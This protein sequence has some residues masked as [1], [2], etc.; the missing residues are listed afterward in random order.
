MPDGWRMVQLGEVAQVRKGQSFT[1]RDLIVGEIPVIAGGMAPAYY[2]AYSNREANTIT[3]SASGAHAGFVAFHSSPILATDCSTIGEADTHEWIAFIYQV[4]KH[5]QLSLYYR[6]RG[7]AQP[8]VYPEDIGSLRIALPPLPEQHAIADVLD[9]ID[10]AIERTE[11]VIAATENLHDS[12]LHEL[13]TRGVP[14]WHTEWKDVPG[15]GTIPADWEVVRLGEVAR[16]RN[17][18]TPSRKVGAYWVDGT[19]PF[20]KTGRV[21]DV[22]I[23]EPDEFIT[24]DAVA[25]SGAVV[26]PEGSVLIAMI[27]QGK[28]RGMAARLGFDAAI[29]QN[30]AAV[31][32][33]D[34]KL[35]LDFFFAYA[36][37]NY[38]RIRGLGQGSNQDAL[39]C[40]L[41]QRMQFALP[42]LNE[43]RV[44]YGLIANVGETLSS[45][46]E[47][48]DS[49]CS[50]KDATADHLLAGRARISR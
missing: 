38:L 44:L 46:K 32:D 9:S 27:G 33:P 1:S 15:I 18:T 41:I 43:Q 3:I 12:L 7:S 11:A 8:H 48:R 16:V 31:Y 30:F 28:T 26:I 22:F 29:N 40:D 19:F 4:L 37:H 14:G 13:L 20:V 39:N 6:R 25:N 45:A 10:E 21:N 5:N 49:L 42:P 23:R 34:T 36:S 47:E 24:Q 2:H 50:L 17:G 35:D